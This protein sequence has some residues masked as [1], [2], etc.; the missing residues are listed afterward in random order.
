MASDVCG[1]NS[2]PERR[3][4][5]WLFRFRYAPDK[6]LEIH[7]NA[8][9]PAASEVSKRTL[10]AISFHFGG[11]SYGDDHIPGQQRWEWAYKKKPRRDPA[12]TQVRTLVTSQFFVQDGIR[13][14]T[15]RKGFMTAQR[16][17]K[18][19]KDYF[20]LTMLEVR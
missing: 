13:N 18:T 20:G 8:G 19:S 17:S 5:D 3:H 14:R 12:V 2:F 1:L 10:V 4:R 11:P 7:V 16:T 9:E 15:N 6:E